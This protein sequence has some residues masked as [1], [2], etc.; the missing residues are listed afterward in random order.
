MAVDRKRV[1][2]RT[3]YLNEA[4]E[5]ASAEKE[6]GGRLPAYAPIPW[7]TKAKRLSETIQRVEQVI[8]ASKDPLKDERFFVLANP[9]P[10]V[11]KLSENKR[12]C[13]TRQ[14]QRKHGVWRCTWE[15]LRAARDGSA[16]SNR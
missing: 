14:I 5:L 13:A 15:G 8:V 4:H 10:E 1:A 6:G 3:F 11:E 2:P 7:A 9:V 16:A 12:K